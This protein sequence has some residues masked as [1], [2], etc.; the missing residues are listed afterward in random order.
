MFRREEINGIIK[1]LVILLKMNQTNLSLSLFQ[2]SS[3]A[4]QC[5]SSLKTAQ[6]GSERLTI[7]KGWE[8]FFGSLATG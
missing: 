6:A 1:R 2:Q 3:W 7:N 5:L 8:I 4:S